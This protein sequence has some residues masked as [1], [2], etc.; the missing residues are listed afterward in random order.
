MR[1]STFCTL[2]LLMVSALFSITLVSCSSDDDDNGVPSE[3]IG[4]WEGEN[5]KYNFY[6]YE[7]NKDGK[8]YAEDWFDDKGVKRERWAITYTYNESK[9][10]LTIY[11][12]EDGEVDDIYTVIELTYSK[13]ILLDN[14]GGWEYTYNKK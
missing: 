9:K 4:R 1:K 6:A 7:F 10:I 12:A 11:D 5:N 13:M 3:L 2:A 14:E 8:G